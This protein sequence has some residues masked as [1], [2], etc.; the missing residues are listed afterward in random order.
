MLLS[1]KTDTN[2]IQKKFFC[3]VFL[4][5]LFCNIVVLKIPYFSIAQYLENVCIQRSPSLI[6]NIDK[7][8]KDAHK[9]REWESTILTLKDSK[10]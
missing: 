4:S 9:P 6:K 10:M 8:T 7:H 2:K 3:F 5:L 1:V